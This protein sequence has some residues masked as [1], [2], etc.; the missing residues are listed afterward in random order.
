M[1]IRC[2]IIL[3]NFIL[4]IEAGNF[5]SE[6]QEELYRIWEEQEGA[7]HRRRQAEDD[8]EGED[9]NETEVQRA[10]RNVMSDGQKFRLRVMKKLFDSATSGAVRRT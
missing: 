5:N 6:W 7:E 9:D 1:W 2:C 10:R 3:H 4:R 8:L